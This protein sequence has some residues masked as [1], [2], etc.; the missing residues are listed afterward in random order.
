MNCSLDVIST[1][2]NWIKSI[3]KIVS[4]IVLTKMTKA[5]P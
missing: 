4:K 3:L 5:Q 1:T 2:A